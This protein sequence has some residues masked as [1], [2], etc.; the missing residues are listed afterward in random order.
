[1][2]PTPDRLVI[3]IVQDVDTEILAHKFCQKSIPATK[4]A[5]TGGFLLEGNITFLIAIHNEQLNVVLEI[6][7][8]TCKTKT[9]VI[10]TPPIETPLFSPL[11][12]I[13]Y[14]LKVQIGGATVIVVPILSFEKI[15]E[16]QFN[17]Q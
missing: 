16:E 15:G 5:S 6:V 1:M 4:I 13:S 9:R 2:K 8:E 11:P 7:R 14:P 3:A 10:Q 12:G 17:H